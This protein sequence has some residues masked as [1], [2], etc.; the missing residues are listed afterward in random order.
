[1]GHSANWANI[2]AGYDNPLSYAVTARDRSVVD[3]VK[4]AVKHK[5]VMLAY[6]AVVPASQQN[7]PAF[8]EG[9]IR[10]LDETGRIIPAR[11]FIDAIETTE[12]GRVIDCLALEKGIQTLAEFPDLRLAINMS[13]RSIGYR[14]WGNI[15]QKGL[16]GDPTIAERLILEITE[17]S[18][19]LVPELVVGFMNDLQRQGISFALDDFGAGYTSFKYLKDFFFDILKIDGQFIRGIANDADNQILTAA[20][21]SIAEQFDMLT[22]AESV[23]QPDDAA[24]L[25]AMGINCLQGYYFGA[26]TVN[27]PWVDSDLAQASA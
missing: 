22:V 3:M 13:A 17:S 12:T 25:T 20:L 1:M 18:A 14:P 5:Q 7:Q 21:A 19:M 15:L 8:Y 27:P 9:L 4:Q 11:D 16:A 26:P 24:Y 6:Q 10:I 23:E 2:Q